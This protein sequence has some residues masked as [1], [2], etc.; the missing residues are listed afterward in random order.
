MSDIPR[1]TSLEKEFFALVPP[2]PVPFKRRAVWWLL[3]ALA[4]LPPVQMLIRWRARS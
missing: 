4:A 1:H 2:R 3:F